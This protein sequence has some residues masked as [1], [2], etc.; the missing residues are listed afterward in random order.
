MINAD[1]ETP[2]DERGRVQMLDAL[3]ASAG[4]S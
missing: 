3:M 4:N 2:P 1:P